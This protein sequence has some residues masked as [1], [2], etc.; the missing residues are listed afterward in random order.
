M[1][2]MK[3]HYQKNER[4]LALLVTLLIMTALLGVSASLL[5]VTLKQYQFSSIALQSEM[6]FQAA[7][8]GLNCILYHDYVNFPTS[9]FDVNGATGVPPETIGCMGNSSADLVNGSNSVLSGEEQRF[10]F[11]WGSPAVC[12]DVSI[13]KFYNASA[14]QDMTAVVGKTASC[15]AGAKCTVVKARGYNVGCANTS[16]PRTIE[17]EITQWN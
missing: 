2:N 8:A 12:S 10:Q 6:A 14:A 16:N 9:K 15:A 4:G 11:T 13:Y 5:N 17:R 3:L 7:N 1:N